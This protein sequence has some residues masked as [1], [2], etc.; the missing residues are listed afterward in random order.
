MALH[1]IS[2]TRLLHIISYTGLRYVAIYGIAKNLKY[3]GA[4]IGW[5]HNE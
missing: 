4:T 5:W 1:M 2:H 3:A